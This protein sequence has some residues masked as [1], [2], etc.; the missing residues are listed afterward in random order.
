MPRMTSQE[1]DAY[2]ARRASHQPEHRQGPAVEDERQIHD[3]ILAEC[4]RRGLIAFHGNMAHRTFRTP[5]EPDF[6]ILA[7]GGRCLLVECKTRLGKL[8]AE[9]LGMQAMAGVLGHTI[10]VVRS[11]ADFLNLIES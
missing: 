5:G 3:D 2:V 11:L 4:R 1:W 7:H 10:H 9:Q 8:S 6:V